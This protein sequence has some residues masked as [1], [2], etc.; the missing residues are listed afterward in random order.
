MNLPAHNDFA[1]MTPTEF[2][3]CRASAAE[4]FARM[5]ADPDF[6]DDDPHETAMLAFQIVGEKILTRQRIISSN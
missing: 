1:N 4:T 2:E 6:A 3:T 5:S